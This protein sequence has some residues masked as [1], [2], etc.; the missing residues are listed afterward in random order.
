M[1]GNTPSSWIDGNADDAT[2]I[3]LPKLGAPAR[4][5]LAGAG[6]THLAQL[7]QVSAADLQK[8]HGVGQM[9]IGILSDALA[10]RGLTF[11]GEPPAQQR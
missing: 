7:T 9:A 1:S 2:V 10:A 3:A 11:A 4:R 8:L 5:A 6:Y